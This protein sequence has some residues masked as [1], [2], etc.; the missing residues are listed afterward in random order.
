MFFEG[1]EKKAEIQINIGQISLLKDIKD[2]FWQAMVTS[3]NAQIISS[4]N[5]ENCKAFLL[6]E[7]SLFVWN[8]RLL[9]LTCGETQLVNAIEYFIKKI[10][11]DK[12]KQLTY[13]RKNEYFSHAQPSC[14]GDDIKLLSQYIK[15]NAYRFGELDG[16]HNFLFHYENNFIADPEDKTYEFLAYQINEQ[17]SN[18]LTSKGIT[19]LAIRDFL[20]INK[21]LPDFIIDD[22][23]FQP[24]GYSLNA[25]KADRYLTIHITPQADSSY[26]SFESNMDLMAIAPLFIEILK[27]LSFDILSFNEHSFS[28]KTTLFKEANYL[29]KSLVQQT[30]PNGYHVNF[31]NF[32][33][34]QLEFTQP[35]QVHIEGENNAL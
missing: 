12:I 23:V 32:I 6:S 15:G 33:L 1:A 35:I 24:Y 7:S 22:Y 3:C 10:G 11:K 16:H 18:L 29:S 14:F 31:A 9:I 27:P 19:A 26:I 20:S 30:L 8:D 25:I 34:P 28:N 2:T 5:N 4:I 21:I 13:Q 17:A